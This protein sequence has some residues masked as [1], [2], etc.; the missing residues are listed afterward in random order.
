ME[1]SK[2]QRGRPKGNGP[3]SENMR[4]PGPL[5]PIVRALVATWNNRRATAMERQQAERQP[6]ANP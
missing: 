1:P 3:H 6:D 4:I 2:R 5:V